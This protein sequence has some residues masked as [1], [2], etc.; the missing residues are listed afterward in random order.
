MRG[1]RIEDWREFFLFE[2]VD[3]LGV[4]MEEKVNE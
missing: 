2:R 3:Q 4:A 1:R